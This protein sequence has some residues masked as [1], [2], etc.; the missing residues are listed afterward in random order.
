MNQA[1]VF[2]KVSAT[3]RSGFDLLGKTVVSPEGEKQHPPALPKARRSTAPSIVSLSSLLDFPDAGGAGGA[4]G[5][6][7]DSSSEDDDEYDDVPDVPG[8]PVAEA[9]VARPSRVSFR[10]QRSKRATTTQLAQR[11]KEGF[12]MKKRGRK[13]WH[14]RWVSVTGGL[15]LYSK[16]AVSPLI[17]NIDLSGGSAEESARNVDHGFIVITE[18]RKMLLRAED[19]KSMEEWMEAFQKAAS[20]AS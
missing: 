11:I 1:N 5:A 13:G 15:L 4:V 8:L 18:G 9:G 2:G 14:K 6:V 12:L 10:H 17:Y 20:I 16:S 3:H 19:R 7:V